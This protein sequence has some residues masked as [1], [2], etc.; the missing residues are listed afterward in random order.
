MA[1]AG[2]NLPNLDKVVLVN[3]FCEIDSELRDTLEKSRDVFSQCPPDMPETSFHYWNSL[4]QSKEERNYD[5]RLNPI[6]IDGRIYIINGIVM[7]ELGLL[8]S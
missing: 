3:P 6:S 2:N 4:K 8:R 1:H 5:P 7:V